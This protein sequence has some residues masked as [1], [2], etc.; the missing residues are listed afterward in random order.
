M[1]IN[2]SK[3]GITTTTIAVDA[4]AVDVVVAAA[5]DAAV[6]VSGDTVGHTGY[7]PIVEETVRHQWKDTNLMLLW[8]TAWGVTPGES[9]HDGV[10]S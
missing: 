7:R 9:T 1:D 4:V 3:I 10:G 5:A 8:K 6:G 2:F